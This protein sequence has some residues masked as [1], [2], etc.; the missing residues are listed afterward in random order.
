MALVCFVSVL[1]LRAF[2]LFPFPLCQPFQCASLCPPHFF[3]FPMSSSSPH[4]ATPLQPL[5][6]DSL[7]DAQEASFS[8]AY[9]NR[10]PFRA[11]P[12]HLMFL[13]FAAAVATLLLLSQLPFFS[14][15]NSRPSISA[16]NG[17]ALN[18]STA[19][20]T[21]EPVVF[22]L[23]MYS[24]SS[25]REGAVLLKVTPQTWIDIEKRYCY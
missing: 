18:S 4:S 12:R 20:R 9:D 5:R 14:S 24:E 16:I 22:A 21:V 15:P 25:A 13:L 3:P 8:L 23:I 17:A 11:K 2:Y 6:L 7:N 19:V 10:L 1:I